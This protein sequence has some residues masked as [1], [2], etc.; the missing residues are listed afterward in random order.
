MA[1]RIPTNNQVE[2]RAYELFM[3][4][5]GEHG[6]AIEDWVAA[7]KELT[8]RRDEIE[9]VFRQEQEQPQPQRA[10]RQLVASAGRKK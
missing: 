4:R 3:E 9:A 6:H 5:G 8:G 1:D 10:P 7:E 2:R